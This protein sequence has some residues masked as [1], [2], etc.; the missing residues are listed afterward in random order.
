MFTCPRR[1]GLGRA[2]PTLSWTSARLPPE[3]LAARATLL[4][5][6]K[7]ASGTLTLSLLRL[8]SATLARAR[9]AHGVR[10]S[11]LYSRSWSRHVDNI[12][13]ARTW[14]SQSSAALGEV[15]RLSD[16]LRLTSHLSPALSYA[17]SACGERVFVVPSHSR[18]EQLN[19]SLQGPASRLMHAGLVRIVGWLHAPP[20]R[21]GL[22]NPTHGVGNPRL[23]DS[24]PTCSFASV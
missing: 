18:L 2:L 6:S 19:T 14:L 23:L 17:D 10:S 22:D 5:S 8:V 13:G 15:A 20:A 9:P 11:S 21:S 7:T 12:F 16:A 1:L 4:A 3:V 24:S